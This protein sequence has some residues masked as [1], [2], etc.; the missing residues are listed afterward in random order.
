MPSTVLIFP[1][2]GNSGPQHWQTLWEQAN[3]DFVR[4]AQRDWDKPLCEEW[5]AVLESTVQRIGPSVVVVAHSLG[6]LAVAHWAARPH[7]PIKAALLVAVPNPDGPN[8]PVEA[9]GFSP[10]PH[11]RFPFPS[12]VV[13]SRND[14]YGSPAHAQACAAAWG[15]RLVDIGEAGH[16]NSGSGLGA[17][18]EG[19]ELL[20]QLRA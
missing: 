2:L 4:I 18:Q 7:A 19:F 13:A 10:V 14:P 12:I 5:V 3:P 8:F 20:N 6:C 9:I 1:G 15:S 11:R 17:W 16:I